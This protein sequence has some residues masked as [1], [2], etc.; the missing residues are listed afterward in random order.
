MVHQRYLFPQNSSTWI[1]AQAPSSIR[2]HLGRAIPTSRSS[3]QSDAHPLALHAL[4][5]IGSQR[6]WDAYIKYLSEQHSEIV[7]VARPTI[8]PLLDH[9]IGHI[10]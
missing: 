9:I 8:N 6:H 5:L 4:F 10:S 2:G 3:G 7:T 1:I